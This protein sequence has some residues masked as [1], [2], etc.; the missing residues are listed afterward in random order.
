MLTWP[1]LVAYL[2]VIF[3]VWGGG[4]GLCYMWLWR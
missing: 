3:T 1:E 4:V 2:S